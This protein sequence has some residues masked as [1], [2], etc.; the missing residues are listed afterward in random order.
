MGSI[1]IRVE[2]ALG[3]AYRLP[4]EVCVAESEG[5]IGYLIEQAL[6]CATRTNISK[7]VIGL[8]TEVIVDKMILRSKTNKTYRSMV[9]ARTSKRIGK[10]GFK[11]S[12]K[13]KEDIEES[14]PHPSQ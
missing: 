3:K 9:Y 6:Q 4:L 10:K 7:P 14:L 8:L 12:L 13:L 1:L 5:E 11:W 2:E